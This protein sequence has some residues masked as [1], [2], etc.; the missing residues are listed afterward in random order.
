MRYGIEFNELRPRQG[1]NRGDA[2]K[3]AD[4]CSALLLRPKSTPRDGSGHTI[5]N[6]QTWPLAWKHFPKQK[7]AI[8]VCPLLLM[9]AQNGRTH[10][11]IAIV[12]AGS[13]PFCTSKTEQTIK[14]GKWLIY[15]R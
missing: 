4:L 2:V 6:P 7:L 10:Y 1:V 8:V 9:S 11:A 14:S 5:A 3:I 15:G 12:Q 13:H